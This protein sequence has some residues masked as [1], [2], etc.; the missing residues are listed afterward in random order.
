MS[1]IWDDSQPIYQQLRERTIA[2]I[3]AGE[4]AEGEPLPSVRQIAVDM[5]INPIT[6]SKAYQM[7]VDDGLVE[8][9][10]GLGMFVISG[11]RQRL[12]ARERELFLQ[13]EWPQMLQ[14]M[15]TLGIDLQQMK[16]LLDAADQNDPVEDQT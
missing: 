6:V 2:R 13:H 4:L 7:L 1:S 16:T 11:A 3:L 5:Q 14:R 15:R 12:L 10:R 9:R 8:K